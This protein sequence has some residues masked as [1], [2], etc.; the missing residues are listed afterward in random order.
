MVPNDTV[1]TNVYTSNYLST[2][3]YSIDSIRSQSVLQEQ[4]AD[5]LAHWQHSCTD[6][7]NK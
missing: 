6:I 1:L 5:T 3:Q 7:G 2:V 4:L